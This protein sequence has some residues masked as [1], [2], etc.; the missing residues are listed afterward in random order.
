[1][2]GSSLISRVAT[3]AV[4]LWKLA[5]RL[6]AS[7]YRNGLLSR[8]RLRAKVISIGNIAWGGTGKTPFT[9]WLARRLEQSGVRVSILTR[10]YRRT[11]RQRIQIIRPMTSPADASGSGDEVQLFLR[12]LGVLQVPIGVSASRYE[13]GSLLEREY[14]VQ[15]HL[16]DDGYQHLALH[17]DLDIVLLDA[18]NPWG[19]HGAVQSFLRESPTALAR[20]DAVLLTRCELLPPP[21]SRDSVRA[22]EAKVRQI[23]PAAEFFTASTRLVAFRDAGTGALVPLEKFRALRPFAFCGLGNPRAFFRSLDHFGIALAGQKVFLDHH[24]YTE[25]EVSELGSLAKTAGAACLLT[26]EKDL[27][28]LS[29]GSLPG[30]PLYWAEIDL[31][32]TEE[33]RL[34]AWIS[35]RLGVPAA[36]AVSRVTTMQGKQPRAHAVSEAE[37]GR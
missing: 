37:A 34:L 11:S 12:Q 3:G 5:A 14:P 30:L 17:R 16:L 15:V 22:L 28:N 32:V 27:V 7:L 23:N 25:S 4:A 20:A 21:G 29:R 2:N 36:A 31:S 8:R 26:T 33:N 18:E 13:A 9:I 6:R 19:R 35:E 24:R 10:G 1:M